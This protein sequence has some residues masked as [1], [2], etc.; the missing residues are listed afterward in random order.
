[1]KI[2]GYDCVLIALMSN[3]SPHHVGIA[4]LCAVHHNM[5]SWNTH[6]LA[7]LRKL[8]QRKIY[9]IFPS[10]CLTLKGKTRKPTTSPPPHEAIRTRIRRL[11]FLWA[12]FSSGF[13]FFN[14]ILCS[15]FLRPEKIHWQQPGLNRRSLDLEMSTLPRDHRGYIFYRSIKDLKCGLSLSCSWTVMFVY[16]IDFLVMVFLVSNVKY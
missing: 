12:L 3:T 7:I 1:M 6:K 13:R 9:Q 14:E 15:G 8:R 10:I 2:P 4:A 5:F 11:N 16:Q